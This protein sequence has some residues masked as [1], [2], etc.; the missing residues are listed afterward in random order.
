MPP[1]RHRSG[2]PRAALPRAAL[3]RAVPYP[4]CTMLTPRLAAPYHSAPPACKLSHTQT[5]H[6]HTQ[7]HS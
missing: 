5:T 7:W 6:T 3:R 4:C 1:Q 2:L